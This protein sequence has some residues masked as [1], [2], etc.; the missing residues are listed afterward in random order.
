MYYGITEEDLRRKSLQL[1][2]LDEDPIGYDFLG[3]TRVQ[4]KTL[5]DRQQKDYSVYL[6]HL[7][8]V[9]DKFIVS[10]SIFIKLD[11]SVH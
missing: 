5:R 3:E 8:P 2:V 9:S 4:L 6:E 7:I 11:A 10:L 1:C